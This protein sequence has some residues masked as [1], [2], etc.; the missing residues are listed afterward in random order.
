MM[1]E[2]SVHIGALCLTVDEQNNVHDITRL[3]RPSTVTD[4]LKSRVEGKI[5]EVT[6]LDGWIIFVIS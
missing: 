3:R 5:K 2:A 1:N 4:K 6:F